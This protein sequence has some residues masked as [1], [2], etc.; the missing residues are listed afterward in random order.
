MAPDHY[1]K[2]VVFTIDIIIWV[3]FLID[4]AFKIYTHKLH[5]TKKCLYIMSYIIEA[6]I[7]ITSLVYLAG[8]KQLSWARILRT[9]KVVM[10]IKKIK[11]LRSIMKSLLSSI[12][13]ILSIFLFLMSFY[14]MFDIIMVKFYAG[15]Y[16]YCDTSN[17]DQKI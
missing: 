3:I 8:N 17:I 5:K 10:V 9:F 16:Y 2:T 6:S 4:L 7:L 1:F 12:Q 11:V 14:L 13:D 15:Y